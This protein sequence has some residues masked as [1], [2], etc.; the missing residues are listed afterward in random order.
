MQ[1]VQ[2]R[3]SAAILCAAIG[4]GA[5]GLANQAY[6]V[7]L[8]INP[9]FE[10]PTDP[11]NEST[12]TTGWT[13][14]STSE[15]AA[16]NNIPNLIPG[17][18]WKVWH[19]AFEPLGGVTQTVN[20]VTPNTS[21]TLT[22]NY[23]FESN[24]A[25]S[26]AISDLKLT[27]LN[28]LGQQIGS[29]DE[30]DIQPGTVTAEQWT[31][32]TLTRTAPA[33]ASKVIVSFDWFNG[34]NV[35]GAQSAF[36]D[37][38]GLDGAGIPPNIATWA[39]NGSGDWNQPGSWTTGSVPNS[40]GAEVRFLDAISANQTV[41]TNTGVTVGTMTLNNAATYVITGAGSI[42][43]QQTGSASAFV[44]VQA[45]VQKINLPLT[46]ASNTTFNVSSGATLKISDPMTINTG[47]VVSQTGTGSVIYESIVNIQGNAVL[48]MGIT[49]H[50][51]ALNIADTG[52]ATIAL[53]GNTTLK[54]DNLSM[55]ATSRLDLKDNDMIVANSNYT[56][57][58]NLIASA[59]NGGSWNG[60]GVTSTVAAA[61]SPKNKTL[62]TITGTQFHQ[63]QGAN[64]LFN[65]FTVA[66]TDTLVKF[67]YYG[68][69]DLNGIVNFD[70]YSRTD[71]GFNSGGNTWF[72]GDFDY[73]GVV[74]FDDYSLIDAAFNTQAGS[75]RQAL[76][77][78]DGNDRNRDHMNTPE[79]QVVVDHFDQFGL[80]YAQSFL[81][82]VPEP[83]SV[84]MVGAAVALGTL[85]RR[86]TSRA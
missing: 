1:Y 27:W 16:F 32:Y 4:L 12:T 83:G 73:N 70:D 6:A 57:I 11:G 38:V 51:N 74:N 78:L 22:A 43:L 41:Y 65:G 30:L 61:A 21:Y 44:N 56:T 77:Y 49:T 79:L 28:G 2:R 46:I 54:T 15:R 47:K 81:N 84:A 20:N 53:N 36:V 63:A 75:L 24:Y 55:G 33:G 5:F 14:Y 45:G 26:G 13:H 67:T 76:A 39:V 3:K 59:R 62:G 52:N 58:K 50:M 10:S 64:Q 34:Q 29:P 82:A 37:D 85:R 18:R 7:N 80:P 31:L 25:S 19:R 66:N 9:G 35:G 8:L 86:R 40:V 72:Q 42:T 23:Y 60:A 17:T 48:I 68:D 69:A 71:A